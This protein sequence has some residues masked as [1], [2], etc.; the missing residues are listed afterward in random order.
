[1]ARWWK[2]CKYM[3]EYKGYVFE[4]DTAEELGRMVAQSGCGMENPF[5]PNTVE[6]DQFYDSY[7]TTKEEMAK[8]VKRARN[9]EVSVA[10]L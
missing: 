7:A 2:K 4:Y 10:L 9:S 3:I 5:D 8:A 6:F 1:M